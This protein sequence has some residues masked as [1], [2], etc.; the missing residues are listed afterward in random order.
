MIDYS[1]G[2]PLAK[3]VAA[4]TAEGTAG[5]TVKKGQ[6]VAETMVCFWCLATEL[7]DLS[8]RCSGA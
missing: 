8:Q 1:P 5:F 2:D 4:G 3:M 7:A 6:Q